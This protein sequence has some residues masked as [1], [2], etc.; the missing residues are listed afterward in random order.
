MKGCREDSKLQPVG[1][2]G[3]NGNLLLGTCV[4]GGVCLV[5]VKKARRGQ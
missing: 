2:L 1:T 3:V 5:S 4:G